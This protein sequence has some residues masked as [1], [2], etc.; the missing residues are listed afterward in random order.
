M[1]LGF[2]Q[3]F[4]VMHY[5]LQYTGLARLLSNFPQAF[6]TPDAIVNDIVVQF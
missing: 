2:L 6:Y 5:S 1:F 3:F 4:S